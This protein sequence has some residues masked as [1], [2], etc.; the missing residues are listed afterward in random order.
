[1]KL[2]AVQRRDKIKA[3]LLEKETITVNEIM[4][5]FHISVETARRDLDALET[6]GFLV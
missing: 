5:L 2:L 3:L 4:S 1:M 6:E